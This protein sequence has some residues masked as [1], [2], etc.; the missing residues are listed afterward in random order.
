[1]CPEW[2]I[3]VIM[4]KGNGEGRANK[5][6]KSKQQRMN[7]YIYLDN[8]RFQEKKKRPV[9]CKKYLK[10]AHLKMLSSLLFG[11]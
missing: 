10:F 11:K 1:M 8:K 3:E 4:L 2:V 5:R 9:M 6:N 7:T